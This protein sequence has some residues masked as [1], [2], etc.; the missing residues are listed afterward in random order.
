MEEE[1]R[2]CTYLDRLTDET[3][4]QY[5]ALDQL[6]NDIL[7]HHHGG[8]L[9]PD[10]LVRLARGYLDMRALAASGEAFRQEMWRQVAMPVAAAEP[11]DEPPT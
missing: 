7:S 10:P 9:W 5:E 2:L 1:Q 4:P 3:E 8:H 11:V 6:A